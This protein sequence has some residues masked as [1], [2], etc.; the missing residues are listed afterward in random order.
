MDD[1]LAESDGETASWSVSIN[2]VAHVVPDVD[3][4]VEWY[5]DVLGFQVALPPKRIPNDSSKVAG[6][7]ETIV[8]SFEEVKMAHL[9]DRDGRGL[10]LFEYD[11][12]G[13]AATEDRR[14][15]EN[16]PHTVGINHF[17]I[18]CEAIEEVTRRVTDNGGSQYTDI[19]EIDPEIGL[20]VT[21]LTDPW[22]N[23]IEVSTR[24]F[25]HISNERTAD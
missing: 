3:A 1:A 7:F 22:D 17:A 11:S 21:Y 20:R 4:A 25:G 23:V 5:R 24:G 15:E 13:E 9:V 12:I 18:T 14:S 10:E 8:G 6:R 19:W 2:H 16:W